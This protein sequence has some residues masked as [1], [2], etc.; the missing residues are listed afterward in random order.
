MCT[1]LCTSICA[2]AFV[3]LYT[4]SCWS[5]PGTTAVWSGCVRCGFLLPWCVPCFSTAI[6]ESEGNRLTF[7]FRNESLIGKMRSSL[8]KHYAVFR[9]LFFWLHNSDQQAVSKIIKPVPEGTGYLLRNPCAGFGINC[10]WFSPCFLR[11][12]LHGSHLWCDTVLLPWGNFHKEFRRNFRHGSVK[13]FRR[14]SESH[15]I[16]LKCIFK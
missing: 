5:T 13:L 16:S 2:Q 1:H 11:F 10:S 8:F 3:Q 9:F 7:E 6:V 14:E 4:L 12:E 15:H